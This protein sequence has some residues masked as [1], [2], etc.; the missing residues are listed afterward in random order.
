MSAYVEEDRIR[1]ALSHVPADARDTW[2]QMGMAVKD[3]LGDGGFDLWDD[4]SKSSGAYNE[5]DARSVW[6]SFNG[7]GVTVASLFKKAAEHGYRD[8]E[9]L[10][11]IDAAERERR[12]AVRELDA[13]E[14]AER[15]ARTQAEAADKA[16]ELWEKAGTVH[17]DHAYI[18]SKKIKPYGA[19]QLREQIV[20]KIQDVDGVHHSAQYIQPDGSKTFQT[21]GHISGCFAAVTAGAKPNANTPLLI[22]EGFAT[23]CSLHEATG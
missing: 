11:P 6:R 4:W 22:A 8:S 2:V 19:K 5:S 9:P 3:E 13:K 17:A 18:R 1:A 20:I 16:R 21:G 10:K 7:G 23:A 15:H 12:R 14:V